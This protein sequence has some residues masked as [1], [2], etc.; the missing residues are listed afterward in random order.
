MTSAFLVQCDEMRFLVCNK[1][2]IAHRIKIFSM[3]L[4]DERH[5]NDK[6]KIV[7]CLP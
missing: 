1:Q 2:E 5:Q 7:T 3:P 6:T 4:F